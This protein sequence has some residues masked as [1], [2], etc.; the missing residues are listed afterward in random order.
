MLSKLNIKLQMTKDRIVG[1]FFHDQNFIF[2]FYYN[3]NLKL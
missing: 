1:Y 3:Y 2:F